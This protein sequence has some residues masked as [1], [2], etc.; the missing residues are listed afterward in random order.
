MTLLTE[1]TL[2]IDAESLSLKPRRLACSC[3]FKNE[4]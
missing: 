1:A 3:E 4:T 2:R